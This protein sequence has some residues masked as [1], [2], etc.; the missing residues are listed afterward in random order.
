MVRGRVRGHI[1]HTPVENLRRGR[2]QGH[3]RRLQGG[4]RT[5]EQLRLPLHVEGQGRVRVHDARSREPRRGYKVVHTGRKSFGGQAAWRRRTAVLA[6][7]RR[8]HGQAPRKAA[9]RIHELPED[10]A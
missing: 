4:C 3:N 7:L 6:E 8:A 10:N 5:V 2:Q 1:R 9:D